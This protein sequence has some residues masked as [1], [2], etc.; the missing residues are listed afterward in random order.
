MGCQECKQDIRGQEP[1]YSLIMKSKP[2]E[3]A[4]KNL[5]T[6]HEPE[7]SEVKEP[8]NILQKM[9]PEIKYVKREP[10]QFTFKRKEQV[11]R[12][13]KNSSPEFGFYTVVA[14]TV[15]EKGFTKGA[16]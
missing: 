1:Y 7:D 10:H 11:A 8:W 5:A 9:R 4:R 6:N 16:L 14:T 15:T 12:L 13:E 3:E 2:D